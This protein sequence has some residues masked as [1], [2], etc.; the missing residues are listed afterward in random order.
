MMEITPD[1]AEVVP[2]LQRELANIGIAIN[3]RKTF[4]LPPKG[5]VPTPE[6]ISLQEGIA[7]RIAER[8]RVKVVGS[9]QETVVCGLA[10]P[11]CCC[12]AVQRSPFDAAHR[13]RRIPD[14]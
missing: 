5:H 13:Y 11:L 7:V 10:V 3:P 14:G 4:A 12:T 2:L 6:E 8:G 1:T 9:R